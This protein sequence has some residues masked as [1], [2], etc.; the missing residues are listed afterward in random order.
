M[1][2]L[3][4]IIITF[5]LIGAAAALC[6]GSGIYNISARVPHWGITS[7]ILDTVKDRSITVHSSKISAVSLDDPELSAI[8]FDHYHAMCRFCHGA[9]GYNRSEVA[10]GLYP[11]PPSLV[12]GEEQSDWNDAA[13][14]WIVANGI[15]MTGMPS[16]GKTHDDTEL[17]GIV[18]FLR[19]LPAMDVAEY[20]A[21]AASAGSS[22]EAEEEEHH[23]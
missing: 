23:H 18:A 12:S 2:S 10:R 14:Y 22:E 20:Q 7:W 13:L 16:F 11:T 9:P 15:K 5:C 3:L 19:H 1:K 4:V 17:W 21:M 8:G 6:V